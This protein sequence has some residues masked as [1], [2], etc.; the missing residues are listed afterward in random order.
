VSSNTPDRVEWILDHILTMEPGRDLTAKGVGLRLRRAA[1]HIDTATRRR[2]APMGMELWEV[3]ILAEL[4]RTDG[5][6]SMGHLQDLAQLTSGALTHRIGKLEVR[7]FVA[8]T[9]D[10][11]DRRQVLVR[12]TPSGRQRLEDVVAANN[13]AERE[14]F[15][16]LDPDLLARLSDDLRAFLVA[17]EGPLAF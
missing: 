1:H 7:G 11:E 8:R 6:A 17:T 15:D 14:I 3:E 9:M 4:V 5:A 10:P 16:R 13:E 2:L 12:V